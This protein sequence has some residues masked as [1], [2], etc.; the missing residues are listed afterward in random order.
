MFQKIIR[1]LFSAFSSTLESEL[2]TAIGLQLETQS[3]SPHS[4]AGVMSDFSKACGN[5]PWARQSSTIFVSDGTIACFASIKNFIGMKSH[6]TGQLLLRFIIID[7]I[8]HYSHRN[9]T[10]EFSIEGMSGS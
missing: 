7:S 1:R 9:S 8:S 5:T 3:R 2:S 4:W 6:P 10:I